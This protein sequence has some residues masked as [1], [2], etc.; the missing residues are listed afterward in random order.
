M[1]KV[2]TNDR[3]SA[4]DLYDGVAF[5]LVKKMQKCGDFPDNLD[6]FIVSAKYGLI[7]ASQKITF[8]EQKM[9]VKTAQHQAK[10]NCGILLEVLSS[11]QYSEIFANLGFIYLQALQPVSN[12]LTDDIL[13]TVPKG[14][15]GQKLQKMK[16]W[17]QSERV[18]LY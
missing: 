11:K 17:L 3:V 7:H 9:T 16:C 2:Y 13:F 18:S 14:K 4:L 10:Q 6:I 15:I 1:R 5:R 12:W 8:Y